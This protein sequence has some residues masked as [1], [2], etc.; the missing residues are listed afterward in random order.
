M[1]FS[2]AYVPGLLLQGSWPEILHSGSAYFMGVLALAMAI[3]GADPVAGR[4]THLR[5]GM[6]GVAGLLLM[7]PANWLVDAVGLA[8]LAAGLLPALRRSFDW[9]E[10]RS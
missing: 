1:P 7:F 4:T 3:Q 9:R 6:L 5:R 8:M 2:F 10:L